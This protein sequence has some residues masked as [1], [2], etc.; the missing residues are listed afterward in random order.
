MPNYRHDW[1]VWGFHP[2]YVDGTPIKL[3]GGSTRHCNGEVTRRTQEG[4]TCA[5]YRA[6]TAPV[7][8]REQARL[9]VAS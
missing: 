3:T 9:A 6:R 7:G 5:V 1:V 2:R 4:W 8:L